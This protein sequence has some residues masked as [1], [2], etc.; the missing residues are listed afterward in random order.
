MKAIFI[1]FD[2]AHFEDI[3]RILEHLEIR[4]FTY[5]DNVAGCGSKYG[6]PHYGNH[7]W[8]GLNGVIWT[9]VAADKV[10]MVMKMLHKLDSQFEQL[11]L[12]AFIMNVENT[13]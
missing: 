1:S 3:I 13:I 9:V 2:Q 6:E 12:R 10:D 7:A 11:G 5:W 4:G 8:P